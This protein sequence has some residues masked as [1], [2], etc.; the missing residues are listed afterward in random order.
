[1]ELRIN[2]LLQ[3]RCAGGSVAGANI[4]F[5]YKDCLHPFLRQMLCH[6]SP[7]DPAA[8]DGHLPGFIVFERGVA[9]KEAIFQEPE[10]MSRS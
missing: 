1:M 2:F 4:S 7:R 9:G 5:V 3:E 8:D 6:Q 10:R